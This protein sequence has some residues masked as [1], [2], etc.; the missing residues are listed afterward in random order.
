MGFLF[1]LRWRGC[2][3]V[4]LDSDASLEI[5]CIHVNYVVLIVRG[6]LVAN[7]KLTIPL[8]NPVQSTSTSTTNR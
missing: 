3:F 2:L 5:I 1:V 6:K 4:L 7:C 8:Q